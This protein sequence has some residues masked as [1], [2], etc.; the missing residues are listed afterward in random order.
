MNILKNKLNQKVTVWTP[1]AVDEFGKPTFSRKVINGRFES[2]LTKSFSEENMQIVSSSIFYSLEEIQTGSYIKEGTYVSTTTQRF[3]EI[4][5]N[6][7]DNLDGTT[8][9]QNEKTFNDLAYVKPPVGSKQIGNVTKLTD[10]KGKVVGYVS[11]L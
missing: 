9:S 6:T 1:G 4:K 7:F 8:D 5:N 3:N 2:Y 11:W 10:L